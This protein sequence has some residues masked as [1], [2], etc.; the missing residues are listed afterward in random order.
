M[1]NDSPLLLIAIAVWLM[2]AS[3]AGVARAAEVA[4]GEHGMVVAGHPAAAQAGRE[5]LQRGGN[6]MDAAVATALTLGV[7]EQ[8]ASGLGGKLIMLY[9]DAESE[10]VFAIEALGQASQTVGV[11]A[12]VA[13]D[14]AQQEAGP[15]SIAVPGMLAGWGASHQRW[16]ELPWADMVQPAIDAAAGGVVIDRYDVHAAEAAS[17][18]LRAGGGYEVYFP[19]GEPL[20][21]GDVV[22]YPDLAETLT[23]IRDQ[24]P[25]A[26][27]GGALG[28]RIARAVSA[29]GGAM[30]PEDFTDYCPNLRPA[31]A[32]TFRGKRVYS[33]I[34]PATGGSTILLTLACLERMPEPAPDEAMGALDQRLRVLYEVYP[35]V[36]SHIGNGANAVRAL[37]RQLRAANVQ[38]LAH[39]AAELDFESL[40]VDSLGRQTSA[41][42]LAGMSFTE[43]SSCTTHFVVADA[44]GNVVCATQSLGHHFG[45]GV[46]IPGTGIVM[47]NSMNNFT[48]S[49]KS[50]PNYIAPGKRTRSTMA[51]VIVLDDGV[52]ILALGAPGGQRI[53]TA[54]LQVLLGILDGGMSPAEAVDQPRVHLRDRGGDGLKRRQVHLEQGVDPELIIELA[55]HGWAPTVMEDTVMYFGGVNLIARSAEGVWIGVGDDRRTNAARGW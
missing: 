49:Y 32:V 30:S 51:P 21:V 5:I 13:T 23:Q 18:D 38:D 44:A 36:R 19:G 26:M 17:E 10:R 22:R 33:G 16:G 1:R 11:E 29:M 37:A 35:A 14:Q 20:S 6:A 31:P 25:R 55:R 53:Q 45:S 52:P 27:Y 8:W 9:Y 24:G 28:R 42:V 34:P 50:S 7:A 12:F 3:S 43:R 41:E 39:A 40:S 46:V 2:A 54:V 4:R 15:K 47:N 48:T